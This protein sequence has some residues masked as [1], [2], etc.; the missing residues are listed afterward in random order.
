[1][2]H[3]RAHPRRYAVARAIAD[4]DSEREAH[5]IYRA[6]TM[7]EFGWESRFA[8]NLAFYR[9]FAVPRI[10]GLLAHTGQISHH[11]RKRAI[12]TGLWMYE[13]IEHGFDHPR[14]REVVRA[15]NR[16]HHRWSILNED[17]LYVLA[18][19]IV[20]PTRWVDRFGW[21]QTTEV[22]REAAAV[23][24]RELGRRMAITD[25]PE[26]YDAFTAY[27]DAYESTHLAPSA[28]GAAQMAATQ[29]LIDERLPRPLRFL[30]PSAVAALLDER[31]AHAL[32]VQ[33]A[34]AVVRL[35]VHGTLRARAAVVRRQAP[36]TTGWFEPGRTIR[37]LYPDGY[38]LSELGPTSTH[39]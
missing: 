7:L 18:S 23:F 5:R 8:L 25:L 21:R 35:L 28:A 15:L 14:G 13:L 1:M 39:P 6:S 30:G 34:P 9:P 16:M 4:M 22:E 24:Y 26:T 11:P 2:I 29:R 33:P 12:D 19:F 31:L 37:D 10:A 32:S 38:Q 3:L 20:V 27:F 36:R 17:Y